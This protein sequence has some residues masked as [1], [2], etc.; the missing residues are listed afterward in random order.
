MNDDNKN[1]VDKWKDFF[2]FKGP[3]EEETQK[4]R[5]ILSTV[6]YFS[7]ACGF[8]QGLVAVS[9][10]KVIN[11]FGL[12]TSN[13]FLILL[14][15]VFNSLVSVLIWGYIV[16]FILSSISDY[17][18]R[19][20]QMEQDKPTLNK[21]ASYMTELKKMED[22]NV[23]IFTRKQ[24]EEEVI[25]EVFSLIDTLQVQSLHQPLKDIIK[26]RYPQSV[27]K[28]LT[29]TTNSSNQVSSKEAENKN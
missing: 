2:L 11:F 21:I 23:E 14:I 10:D 26:K 29:A 25:K 3:T 4:Q 6:A 13:S 15:A 22:D 5:K 27:Q 1:F 16:K 20:E 12:M 24:K 9:D 19:Q 8:A 28:I 7:S 17:E 18:K